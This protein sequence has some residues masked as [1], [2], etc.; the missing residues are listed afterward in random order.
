[1]MVERR[2]VAVVGLLAMVAGVLQVFQPQ[3]YWTFWESL[4]YGQRAGLY[5]LG[6]LSF[7][8]GLFLLYVGVRRLVLFGTLIW[9][10]GVLSVVSGLAM[11]VTPVFYL[12]MLSALFYARAQGTMLGAELHVGRNHSVL[13]GSSAVDSGDVSPSRQESSPP[14]SCRSTVR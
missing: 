2:I 1:M 14:D 6:L 12:D 4:L 11:L 13:H 9:I 5:A 7:F 3:R 10:V 8:L